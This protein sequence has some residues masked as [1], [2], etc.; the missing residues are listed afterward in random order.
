MIIVATFAHDFGQDTG[1][2]NRLALFVAGDG[3]VELQI[4]QQGN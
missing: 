2:V 1:I 4:K 3:R